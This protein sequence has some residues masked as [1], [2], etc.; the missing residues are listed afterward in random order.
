M[1]FNTKLEAS[2]YTVSNYVFDKTPVMVEWTLTPAYNGLGFNYWLVNVNSVSGQYQQD[3]EKEIV[4]SSQYIRKTV[5]D[6]IMFNLSEYEVELNLV[7]GS[8]SC[9][10]DDVDIV[11]ETKKIIIHFI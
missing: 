3:I 7:N 10:I 9:K 4:I 5:E 2:I 6:V 1:E 8:E 11:H